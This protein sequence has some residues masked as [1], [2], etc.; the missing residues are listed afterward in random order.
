M[1]W[2]K[3]L[4]RSLLTI[5]V[6][7]GVAIAVFLFMRLT[8][9]ADPVD[10][11]MGEAGNVSQAEIERLKEEF[12][13][14][15]PLL[16]Q[17]KYFL[18][19]LARFD[20]GQSITKRAPV[21]RLIKERLPATIELAAMSFLLALAIAVPIGILSAVKQNSILDRLSMGVSFFGLSLPGFWLGIILILLF[22]VKFGWFPT[23]GRIAYGVNLTDI[24]GFH[25]LDSLLT[26]NS[27]AFVSALRHLFLPA[28]TMGATMSATVAR[29]VRSSMLEV[30]RQDYVTLAR[31]KGLPE[32]S[33]I[34]RHALRNALIPTVTVVAIQ[35]GGF[36]AGNMIVETVFGWP[37]VGRLVVEAILRRDFPLVQGAVMIFAFTFIVMNL[38]AD[39]L[40]TL[41]NPKISL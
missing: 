26:G 6:M 36:L 18:T 40:Y 20:L 15:K 10:L 31:A 28:L 1:R 16:V 8:P 11:M 7:V 2:A 27:A 19:D 17:L 22:S 3:I 33:V 32:V 25:L 37:G 29:M 12:N 4:E 23:A 21:G 5:P 35:A 38:M 30:L 41:I 13:L 9:A 39:I 14:D 24:T 34:C